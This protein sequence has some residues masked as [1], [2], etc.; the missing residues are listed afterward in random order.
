M[1]N[2]TELRVRPW[3][4]VGTLAA[5]E[6]VRF[7]RQRNRVFGAIGQPIL[8]WLLFGAGLS[9]SFRLAPATWNTFFPATWR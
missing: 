7:F 2:A 5:R 4:V 1:V 3:E 9:G 8:F 6:L